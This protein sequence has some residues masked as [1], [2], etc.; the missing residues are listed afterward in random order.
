MQARLSELLPDQPAHER[1]ALTELISR[2]TQT[3]AA[4]PVFLTAARP[5]P[6]A[7]PADRRYDYFFSMQFFMIATDILGLLILGLI[8]HLEK[9]GVVKRVGALEDANR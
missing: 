8:L 4:R 7:E 5:V 9:R 1:V 6:A 2:I 3:A